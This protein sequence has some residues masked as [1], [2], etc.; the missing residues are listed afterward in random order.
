MG[1]PQGP[2]SAPLNLSP[3]LISLGCLWVGP[4][5]LPQRTPLLGQDRTQHPPS[6]FQV[7]V[8]VSGALGC[9]YTFRTDSVEGS[10]VINCYQGK[11]PSLKVL[12]WESGEV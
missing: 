1:T 2:P 9:P 4:H 6:Q 5:S 3:L 11:A 10:P 12:S 8:P 7:L